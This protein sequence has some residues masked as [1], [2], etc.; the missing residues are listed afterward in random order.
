MELYKTIVKENGDTIEIYDKE[1]VEIKQDTRDGENNERDDGFY[2]KEKLYFID[3]FSRPA[4][5]NPFYEF[6]G[7][8]PDS[9]F[10]GILIKYI[11]DTYAYDP[12]T[13][14]VFTYIG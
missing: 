6:D 14:Q 8:S 13:I 10:S 2:Y 11:D 1:T 4:F 5:G 3:D 12:E 7:Y 9:F